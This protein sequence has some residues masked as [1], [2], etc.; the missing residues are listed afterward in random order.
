MANSKETHVLYL[1]EEEDH[2]LRY[3]LATR[4]ASC[5]NPVHTRRIYDKLNYAYDLAHN[6][7]ME[8]ARNIVIQYRTLKRRNRAYEHLTNE[9]YQIEMVVRSSVFED[10][11]S[12]E[13][14][15]EHIPEGAV[16]WHI[17]NEGIDFDQ[18]IMPP[19]SSENIDTKAEVNLKDLYKQYIADDN[20]SLNGFHLTFEIK[21]APKKKLGFFKE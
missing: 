17:L 5:I 12:R 2:F 16:N 15:E 3:L 8:E 14:I 19:F 13:Y 6:P 21:K 20:D 18:L 9:K 7:N 11:H 4:E 1:T 10:P